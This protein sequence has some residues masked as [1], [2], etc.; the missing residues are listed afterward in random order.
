MRRETVIAVIAMFASAAAGVTAALAWTVLAG[1]VIGVATAICTA[2]FLRVTLEERWRAR[3]GGAKRF[4]KSSI[5]SV[6]AA[7]MTKFSSTT[8]RKN[9]PQT[10]V[11]ATALWVFP[12]AFSDGQIWALFIS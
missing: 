9:N 1:F 10:F 12:K 6:R 8:L 3:G 5:A 11:A 2:A 4:M 7:G